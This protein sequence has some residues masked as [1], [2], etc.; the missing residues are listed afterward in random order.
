M[1]R[2]KSMET[3][4]IFSCYQGITTI[5]LQVLNSLEVTKSKS[6]QKNSCHY[7]EDY[8]W[9]YLQEFDPTLEKP[10]ILY[11]LDLFPLKNKRSLFTNIFTSQK[12]T[13]KTTSNQ[14]KTR[15][16]VAENITAENSMFKM[17]YSCEDIQTSLETTWLELVGSM[18]LT[19]KD[20]K[21][22]LFH[23]DVPTLKNIYK[24]LQPL[25]QGYSDLKFISFLESIIFSEIP[26]P[27]GVLKAFP[28]PF[29][30]ITATLLVQ[31]R[32]IS[33]K[34]FQTRGELELQTVKIRGDLKN[35]KDLKNITHVSILMIFPQLENRKKF[36][37]SLKLI[38]N[39]VSTTVL[40]RVSQETFMNGTLVS[41]PT[42]K[43]MIPR[44][45]PCQ[46]L[47]NQK[48]I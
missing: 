26:T 12:L 30:S 5:I 15:E 40:I 31:V 46:V 21:I 48:M 39:T 22:H 13:R 17:S 45:V 47:I 33:T 8:F 2:L 37:K 18:R 3:V 10:D 4:Y 20:S 9:Q 23:R 28:L 42:D 6:K 16:N 27:I 25:S 38:E 34:L 11:I 43:K 1:F 24:L 41:V 7:E 36:V 35:S 44:G 14:L 19:S 32:N 29:A